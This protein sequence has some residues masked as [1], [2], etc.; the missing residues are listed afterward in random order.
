MRIDRRDFIASGALTAAAVAFEPGAVL[1]QAGR[2]RID[3]A[4]RFGSLLNSAEFEG[5]PRALTPAILARLASQLTMRGIISTG[6]ARRH[7]LSPLPPVMMQGTA[8]SLGY[9]GS[10][11]AQSF[12]YGLGTYTAAIGFPGFNLAGGP[13]N[14]IS[15]AW[16][17]EWAQS[18]QNKSKCQ[19]SLALP[20]LQ[21][22]VAKGAP[23]A[24][25]V[26]YKPNC[27]YIDGINVDI[28]G[29]AGIKKFMIGSY[30]ALPHFLNLQS[31]Y[32]TQFKQYINAGHAIAFSGLVARGYDNPAASMLK[33]AYDPQSFIPKSGHGQLIVGYDDS[34]GRTGAFLIQNSFGTDWPYLGATS[35]LMQGRLWWTYE[36]FFASQGFGAIAYPIPRPPVPPAALRL[37]S[38]PGAPVA[39]VLEAIRADD[40]GA[41][42]IVLETLFRRPVQL[43]KVRIT[44]PRSRSSI[45][46]GY[47]GAIKYGFAHVS[48]Q[49]PFLAGRY[50][51]ELFARMLSATGT[52]GEAITYRGYVLVK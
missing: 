34:L 52:P 17:F 44:P 25:Q 2:G 37:G 22:L 10:C 46:G 15:S 6:P 19:G 11:E 42:H 51:V 43:V 40:N 41:S 49:A 26:P 28:L 36:A 8:H 30:K 31:A 24:L 32:V 4:G 9:P 16:L 7:I 5:A 47:N 12:G 35:S 20:Y 39:H 29:Y 23:S 45:F 27:A 33:G 13:A 50:A 14:H 3:P 48:R 38:T 21:M 18:N 1:A